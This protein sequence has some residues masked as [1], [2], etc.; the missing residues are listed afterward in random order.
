VIR[1]GVN[2]AV[3][4]SHSGSGN[5]IDD[6]VGATRT[7]EAAGIGTGWL[8][9]GYAHDTLTALAAIAREVPR[10]ELGASVVVVQPRHPRV[11]AAQAQ[12]V[13]AASGGRFTL[14]VGVSHPGLLEVYGLPFHRPF[15]ALREH[16]DTLLPI[17]AGEQVPG[18]TGPGSAAAE[19]T[20]PGGAGV[21]VL[22]GALGP[23]MLALAGERTDGTITVLCGPRTIG[24]HVVPLL[25]AAAAGRPRVV[26]GLPVSVTADPERVRAEVAA[27]YAGLAQLPSYRRALDRD[28]LADAG[29]LLIAGTEE[30]VAAGLARYA[31]LGATDVLVSPAGDAAEQERTVQVLGAM[32]MSEPGGLTARSANPSPPSGPAGA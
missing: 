7:V 3:V 22:L 1:I 11:L 14:G 25:T 4:A 19:T 18:A 16:L 20:V 8:P 17:L 21:P 29:G 32:A 13:Q 30:D 28:G 31:D 6:L 23:R 10:I 12:T 24:E 2:L 27:G 5:L 15:T 26:V 9:Q